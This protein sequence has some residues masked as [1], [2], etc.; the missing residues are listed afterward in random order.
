M[1]VQVGKV[2]PVF[3]RFEIFDLIQSAKHAPSTPAS[4]CYTYIYIFRQCTTQ[5]PSYPDMSSLDVRQRNDQYERVSSLEIDVEV[6]PPLSTL[7][8][9]CM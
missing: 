5:T 1:Y 3:R 8:T 4:Y 6:T 7:I 9:S 2:L